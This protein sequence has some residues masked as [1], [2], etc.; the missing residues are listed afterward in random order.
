MLESIMG[1]I[2]SVVIIPQLTEDFLSVVDNIINID[3]E[4]LQQTQES[5]N[6][7][8]KWEFPMTIKIIN[9]SKLL[10]G[11]LKQLNLLLKKFL[12]EILQN[13]LSLPEVHLLH[14]YSK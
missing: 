8:A 6:T 14:Q 11:F 1:I 10:I 12:L 4:T 9:I 5:S 3:V 13:L 7:S 2:Y